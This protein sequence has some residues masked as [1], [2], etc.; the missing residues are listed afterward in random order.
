MRSSRAYSGA[1]SN[2][3]MSWVLWFHWGKGETERGKTPKIEV[4]GQLR[5]KEWWV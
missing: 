3:G 2:G 1:M 4:R 5:E